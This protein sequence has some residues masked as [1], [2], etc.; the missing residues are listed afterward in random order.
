MDQQDPNTLPSTSK[1]GSGMIIAMWVVILTLLTLYFQHW[2]DGRNN[3]NQHVTAAFVENGVKE[4][5][6]QRNP[7]GHYVASGKI[8][9]EEVQFMLDTGATDISVP[10]EIAS[11]LGLD[12][13]APLTYQTANGQIQ[14]YSSRL[15]EVSL[16]GIRL[17]NV[18][19]SINPH[20]Q[21][22]E[23]LLGMSFLKHLE[24]TQRGNTLTLRQY[25]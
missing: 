24:F 6:L 9:G 13:G 7:W 18:R 12:K 25:P 20:M 14:V 23:I 4:L 17:Q 16:G 22:D 11:R 21:G 10:G 15:D 3:P 8:N 19:A 5:V 2:H 1:L